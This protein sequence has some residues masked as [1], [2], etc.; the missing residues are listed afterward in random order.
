MGFRV[1]CIY[2][3]GKSYKRLWQAQ[4]AS[5]KVTYGLV[6]LAIAQ[7]LL[8]DPGSSDER[9]RADEIQKA[10]PSSYVTVTVI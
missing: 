9:Y 6:A 1:E 2:P 8:V 10:A 3:E 7:R 4:V 5:Y